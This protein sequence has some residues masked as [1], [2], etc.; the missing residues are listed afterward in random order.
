MMKP[1]EEFR[2]Y[3]QAI[4]ND[5]KY[6]QASIQKAFRLPPKEAIE[7]LKR[8]ISNDL[9][10]GQEAIL[11]HNLAGIYLKI[12]N[13]EEAYKSINRSLELHD[14][15]H[16]RQVRDVIRENMSFPNAKNQT[17]EKSEER[18]AND[19][20]TKDKRS[21]E[22][23]EFEDE[24]FRNVF[25]DNLITFLINE[26]KFPRE[27]LNYE[28]LAEAPDLDL[29]V[30]H[31]G[32]DEFL[33]IFEF[34]HGSIEVSSKNINNILNKHKKTIVGRYNIFV[35]IVHPSKESNENFSI[36]K[37][38]ENKITDVSYEKFP[39][40]NQLLFASPLDA[41]GRRICRALIELAKDKHGFSIHTPCQDY[42][43][44]QIKENKRTAAQIHR[45][46]ESDKNIALVL[47]GYEEELYPDIMSNYVV[48]GDIENLSGYSNKYPA[49]KNWLKGTLGHPHLRYK[50]S[51]CILKPGVLVLEDIEK[52]VG[53]LLELAKKN[54]EN[55]GPAEPE[56]NPKRI[57]DAG[58][59]VATITDDRISSVD[60]LGR[61]DLVRALANMFVHTKEIEGFTVALFG[62]WGEGKSTIMDLLKNQLKT[63]NNFEF[64]KFNA[65]EYEHTDNIAAGL[66][67]E[68]VDG[69][70]K[71]VIGFRN[72]LLL[73]VK[74]AW[75]EYK[76]NFIY[77]ILCLLIIGLSPL[78]L[79]LLGKVWGNLGISFQAFL[80]VG[81][82]A[83]LVPIVICIYRGLKQIIEH[84]LAAQ[85]QTY[86]KLPTYGEHLG[87]VP[88]LKRHIKTLCSLRLGKEKKLI[89]F[90]DDLDRCHAECISKTLDAI[91][92]VMTIPR[93]IVIFG[94]DYRIAFKAIEGHYKNVSDGKGEI[95]KKR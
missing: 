16:T 58:G 87:L 95:R 88:V 70:M 6:T 45:L 84:P 78:A 32:T 65:W 26:K 57:L 29:A 21:N 79:Y 54:A 11:W 59:T 47:A 38:E 9:K 40:Y 8:A 18:L 67:Q 3:D 17:N 27:S 55:K 44:L 7:C 42:I 80:G 46:K 20:D 5:P 2:C 76:W 34:K 60:L 48:R 64:A 92:L 52:E 43:D 77:S 83:V 24:D 94:I 69:L 51:V 28:I 56:E 22:D 19:Y 72:R 63:S 68:V 4:E 90:V 39:T 75:C 41:P 49:E 14:N 91:R 81:V 61:K 23:R 89:V 33:A 73:H 10:P 37:V 53:E 74:F 13:Y 71:G 62:N 1:K 30:K 31:P 85:L 66:A 86:L 93:V 36:Y 50:A 12:K 35:Y 15:E 25:R 82:L